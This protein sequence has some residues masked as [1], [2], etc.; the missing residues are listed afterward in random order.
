M[1][2]ISTRRILLA[3]FFI[4]AT[5]FA[6]AAI[7]C[8]SSSDDA[9]SS[10][11]NDAG[12]NS[13]SQGAS[14]A[15]ADS[16]SDGP[17]PGCI[18]ITPS[19]ASSYRTA[20]TPDPERYSNSPDIQADVSLGDLALPDM[21][22]FRLDGKIAVGTIALSSAMV[23]PYM[24][25][26]SA[27][28]GI[29]LGTNDAGQAAYAKLLY[30]TSGTVAI[31][32]MTTPWQTE[33][34]ATDVRF[35]EGKI[36]GDHYQVATGGACFWVRSISW[37]TKLTN[38]CTPFQ[39]TD[40][41]GAGKTCMPTN[42]IGKDGLCVAIGSQNEGDPCT[43]DDRA[44]AGADAGEHVLWDSNCGAGLR[45]FANEELDQTTP[46]CTRVCDVTAAN[47]GCPANTHCGGGYDLCIPDAV[48]T[49]SNSGDMIDP[50]PVGRACAVDAQT[51]LTNDVYCGGGGDN[52]TGFCFPHDAY[53]DGGYSAPTCLPFQDALSE[54]P[55]GTVGSF[56]AYKNGDDGSDIQCISW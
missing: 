24:F 42:A 50:A 4:S 32:S 54:C 8:S 18:E 44:D 25:A 11:S 28:L 9:N 51:T 23:G 3:T 53:A 33:G 45:C 52:R 27:Q 15:A 21:F 13:D 41:C 39:A 47:S 20:A 19:N 37:N 34:T 31:A 46:S 40:S 7:G 22:R 10:A 2:A 55:S 6:S 36:V 35:D 29:D 56:T 5:A 30:A 17:P 16:N 12:S 38:G 49:A 43:F 1:T 26:N 48:F 14:D